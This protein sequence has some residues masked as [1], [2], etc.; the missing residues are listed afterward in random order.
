[1]YPKNLKIGDRII[2]PLNA[3]SNGRN[4]IIT[5]IEYKNNEISKLFYDVCDNNWDKVGN[6][7]CSTCSSTDWENIKIISTEKQNNLVGKTMSTLIQKF[8]MLGLGE[9][10]KTLRLVGIQDEKGDLTEDGK[11]LYNAWKFEQDKK[12][13]SDAVATPLLAEQEKDKK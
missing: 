1:M 9:P 8:K 5:N 10:E 4:C 12:A 11:A 7:T 3:C 2:P 6:D 13:F